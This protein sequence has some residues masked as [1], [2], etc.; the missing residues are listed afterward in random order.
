MSEPAALG[1]TDTPTLDAFEAWKAVSAD[2]AGELVGWQVGSGGA[3]GLDCDACHDEPPD[4]DTDRGTV[5]GSLVGRW[6]GLMPIDLRAGVAFRPV[7]VTQG[8]AMGYAR[9]LAR[10]AVVRQEEEGYRVFELD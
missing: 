8:E 3:A 4:V 6:L 1:P 5:D 2:D 7:F 10:A 9:S